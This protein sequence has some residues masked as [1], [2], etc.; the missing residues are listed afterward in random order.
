MKVIK[1][2]ES[3]IKRI[4]KRVITEQEEQTYIFL[5]NVP[6]R[7]KVLSNQGFNDIEDKDA[8]ELMMCGGSVNR[9]PNLNEFPN[10]FVIN[11]LESQPL[12]DMHVDSLINSGISRVLFNYV[13]TPDM[14]YKVDE[15]IRRGEEKGMDV[16]ANKVDFYDVPDGMLDGE[17]LPGGAPLDF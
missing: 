4:V 13:D 16:N 7:V 8:V 9:L 15:L 2:N 10:L 11:L 6:E 14:E 1:L 12:I 5:N 17:A 3:D